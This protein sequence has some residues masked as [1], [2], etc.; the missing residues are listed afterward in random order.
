MTKISKKLVN[1]VSLKRRKRNI[2]LIRSSYR[3]QDA[4]ND[5]QPG[6]LAE[7]KM[8]FADDLTELLVL[9]GCKYLTIESISVHLK[10]L[11]DAEKKNDLHLREP[12]MYNSLFAIE[13][14]QRLTIEEVNKLLK[15]VFTDYIGLVVFNRHHL[16]RLIPLDEYL[17]VFLST[18]LG[19]EE[20]VNIIENKHLN[21]IVKRT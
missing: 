4:I 14:E 13:D 7:Y 19:Y 21:L 8:K 15:F 1:D 20:M 18:A 10:Y 2:Y 12:E 5:E 3:T 9:S 6:L 16:V 17:T 11:R